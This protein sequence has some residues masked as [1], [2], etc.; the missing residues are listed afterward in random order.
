MSRYICTYLNVIVHPRITFT[1]QYQ[2]V[3]N[4]EHFIE[5]N[6][7]KPLTDNNVSSERYQWS[8]CVYLYPQKQVLAAGSHWTRDAIITSFYHQNDV[9]MTSFDVITTSLLHKVSAVH[10]KYRE[11]SATILNDV[12]RSAIVIRSRVID[13]HWNLWQMISN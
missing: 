9:K 12:I 1:M 13:S 3:N 5:N 2:H 6:F 10:L 7:L 8:C 4:L 11:I